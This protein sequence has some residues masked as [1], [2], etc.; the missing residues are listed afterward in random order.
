MPLELWHLCAVDR[1]SVG[2][3]IRLFCAR[4][5]SDEA[6]AAMLVTEGDRIDA[7]AIAAVPRRRPRRRER[8][9]L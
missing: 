7:P 8:R 6:A 9:A 2:R 4:A 1:D 5:Q 3:R